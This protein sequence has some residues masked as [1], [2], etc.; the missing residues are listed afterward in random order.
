MLITVAICTLNHAESLRRTLDSLTTSRAPHET[1]WE[2][3]IVNNGCTDHTDSV[4]ASFVDLLPIRREFEAQRGLARARNRAIDSARGDYIIWTDD[5]VIID[6]N[7]VLAY[8]EAFRHW[9]HAAVF[10][11]RI[12]PRFIESAPKWV[13]DGQEFLGGMLAIRDLGDEYIPLSIDG[14][15]LPYGPNF[16][17]RTAE[18][19]LFRYNVKLG[20]APGQRR[21]CEETDLVQR[22]LR[23]GAHGYWVPKAKV[24]HCFAHKQLTVRHAADFFSSVGEVAAFWD[25]SPVPQRYIWFGAPRVLWRRMVVGWLRYRVYRLISSPIVWLPNLEAYAL[26]RGRIR[27]WRSERRSGSGG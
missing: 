21:R 2:V 20:H 23:S 26:N 9:P 5:D 4:I 8:V 10:G 18:Q 16:A 19:R 11:G 22:L 3:V 7:W 13:I 6:P 14:W 27:Y 12:V 1:E 24:E 17:V 15:R 25:D